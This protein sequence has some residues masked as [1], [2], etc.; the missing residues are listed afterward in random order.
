[1]PS[2]RS[3]VFSN[4]LRLLAGQGAACRHGKM[5][6]FN[7]EQFEFESGNMKI[8]G[9]NQ[10]FG[11]EYRSRSLHININAFPVGNGRRKVSLIFNSRESVDFE[12]LNSSV[13]EIKDYSFGW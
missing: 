5:A 3:A 12:L 6:F 10:R 2:S 1:M 8:I 7:N 4:S 11:I 13:M 9:K